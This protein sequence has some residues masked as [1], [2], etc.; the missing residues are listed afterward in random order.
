MI[1]RK[2]R[3]ILKPRNFQPT[4]ADL[5]EKVYIP[6]TPEQL[7]KLVTKTLKAGK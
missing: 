7:A 4:V 1:Q 3:L 5:K 2:K 6:T